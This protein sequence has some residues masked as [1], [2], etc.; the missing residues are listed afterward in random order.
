M[1]S[2]CAALVFLAATACNNGITCDTVTDDLGDLCLPAALA[3]G[4]S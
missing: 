3:P 4:I 1:R 2:L